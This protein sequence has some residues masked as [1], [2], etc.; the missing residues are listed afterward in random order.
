M[1]ITNITCRQSASVLSWMVQKE[2]LRKRLE[3]NEQR[4]CTAG[5]LTKT[6]TNVKGGKWQVNKHLS[7]GDVNDTVL[8]LT[9]HSTEK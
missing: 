9:D 4:D 3:W 2:K 7:E 8:V 6:W 1:Q 5:L